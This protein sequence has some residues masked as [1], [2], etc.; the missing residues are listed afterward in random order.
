[1]QYCVIVALTMLFPDVD[2]ATAN[3]FLATLLP[4]VLS[5][6]ISVPIAWLILRKGGHQEQTPEKHKIPTG[7]LI[8]WFMAAFA[9][10]RIVLMITSLIIAAATGE[11]GADPV[12]NLQMNSPWMMFIM[13]VVVAP[14]VEE[15][16]FRGFM[17]KALAP[18]GAKWYIIV[19]SLLFGLF[20]ANLV[21]IPFA[22]T[23]GLFFGYVMYRT[24][25]V[26]IPM[27]LHFIVNLIS[28][29]NMLLITSELGS[30]IV[31]IVIFGLIIAG[32]VIGIV[33]LAKKHF[34]EDIVFDPAVVTPAKA[35]QALINVGMILCMVL[36]IGFTIMVGAES[37]I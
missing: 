1:M 10:S 18:Y 9:A 26:L 15:L 8:V 32:T 13:M 37:G 28:G 34:K 33:L 5:Y 35:N 12:S 20:H 25:N 24:G 16:V 27:L 19:S 31:L 2:P 29:I 30:T 6:M 36:L 11:A 3:P 14:V 21:Q 22:F 17:Y 23:M 7:K 4:I